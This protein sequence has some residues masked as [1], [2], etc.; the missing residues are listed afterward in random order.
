VFSSA[1]SEEVEEL[2][3]EGAGAAGEDDA[4]DDV[5]SAGVYGVA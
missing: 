1:W 5:R 4:E 3:V 2:M